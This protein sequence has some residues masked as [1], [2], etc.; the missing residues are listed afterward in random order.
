[1]PTKFFTNEGENS[2][3]KKFEGVFTYIDSIRYFDA[4]VGYFRASGY[5]KIRPLLERIPKIRILVGINVDHLIKEAHDKGQLYLHNPQETKEQFINEITK[6]VQDSTYD[7]ATEKGIIQFIDDIISGKIEL[8]AHP[9]KKIHAKVYI[10][11]S[12]NFNEYAPCE[13]ITGSSNLTDAG[14]GANAGSNYEFNVSLRDYE[15]VK[16]ASD[17]FEKLWNESVPILKEE[18]EKIKNKTHLREDFTPFELYIKMLIEYFGKRV[19]YD[20]YNINLLLPPK[21]K[22]L[23]YQA[24]AANQGYAIMMKHN[25]FILADVVGL[26]KTIIACMIAKKFIYENGTHTKVLV[27]TPPAIEDNWRRTVK[28]FELDNHFKYISIGSLHKILDK[29]DYQNPNP[30]DIDL[31]IVDESHKFR[32]DY[33]EMY[34]KLQE[35]CKTPRSKPSENGDTRKKVIL[36]SATP[37]NNRPQDIE[38]QLYLFQDKRDSTLEN[39]RNLQEYFKP[40][41][42]QYKELANDLQM[43]NPYDPKYQNKR[44]KIL[45]KLKD[46]FQKLRNDIIEPLVI[47]RTRHD[48]EKV[49]EYL[50]DIKQQGIKFPIVDDPIPLFYKL[51]KKLSMLFYETVSLITGIDENGK[52]TDGLGYFRYRAIEYLVKEEH[53]KIYGE[54]ESISE[55]LAGIMRTLL[56]KRLESSFYAFTQSLTR[57]KNAIDNMLDMFENDT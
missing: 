42:K 54:V 50:E 12:A 35:I 16:F 27:V 26:G 20:A 57:L 10:F 38:N 49:P 19:E 32:N 14:L 4:L 31:I 17:E 33:T 37:L 47:R 53:R 2:L 41:N 51:D 30:E 28:D 36:I 15:D 22:R 24:D 43:L 52:K 7:E 11:K 21:Y 5:F 44:K 6:D 25:G 3:L 1:M 45:T 39:I 13:V 40:I 48:I 9:S 55:K 34:N 18:V 29:N 56:V 8:R 23:K 46:L